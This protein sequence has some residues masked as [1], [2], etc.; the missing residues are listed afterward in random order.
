MS[1]ATKRKHV[2]KEIL[3]NYELPTDKQEI[4]KVIIIDALRFFYL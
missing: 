1:K 4:V 3:D 2:T